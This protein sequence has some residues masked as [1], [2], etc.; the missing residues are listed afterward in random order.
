MREKI[1]DIS[2]GIYI[3]V[4]KGDKAVIDKK[5]SEYKGA[6]H[7]ITVSNKP[8]DI[9]TD[10]PDIN[11]ATKEKRVKENTIPDSSYHSPCT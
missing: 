8:G 7:S 3:G 11:I 10:Q 1:N 5:Y 4:Y 9:F 6:N 2:E